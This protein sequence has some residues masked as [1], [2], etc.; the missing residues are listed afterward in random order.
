MLVIRRLASDS[1]HAGRWATRSEA[2][3]RSPV[4]PAYDPASRD[5]PASPDVQKAQNGGSR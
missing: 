3:E 4:A 1:L 5:A 2:W